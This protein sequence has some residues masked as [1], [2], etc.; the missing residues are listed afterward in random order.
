MTSLYPYSRN[1]TI[2]HL[3]V[4]PLV[5]IGVSRTIDHIVFVGD[6]VSKGPHSLKVVDLAMK[7]N[8]SCV[9]GNHDYN[10]LDWMGFIDAQGNKV[11][12][13][14]IDEG[15]LFK[16]SDKEVIPGGFNVQAA[17]WLFQCPYILRVGKV[18]GEDL[19]A[20]HAG[21]YPGKSLEDQSILM[22]YETDWRTM[23]R[24]EYAKHI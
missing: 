6:L 19:V 11:D 15:D 1:W 7:L 17:R 2:N 5:V 21:L 9:L 10:L 23:G 12:R 13:M 16:G 20:V 14:V 18:D 8:A 4:C 22:F 3:E 24:D